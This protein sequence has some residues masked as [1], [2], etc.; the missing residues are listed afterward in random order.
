[1]KQARVSVIKDNIKKGDQV[2]IAKHDCNIGQ[3]VD[4]EMI[5][6][7]H[8][9]DK[10]GVLDIP[11]Y[12]IDNKTRKYG[13]KTHHTIGSQ[14]IRKIL[15]TPNWYDTTF[16]KKTCNQNQIIWNE[17]FQ[18]VV[19]VSIID[20]DLPEIQEKH[21]TAYNDLRNQIIKDLGEDCVIENLKKNY[22]STCGWAVFDRYSHS[23]SFKYRNTDKAM[24][25]IKNLSKSRNTRKALFEE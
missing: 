4:Q 17:D 25:Q 12:N 16:Y 3:W 21:N 2:P 13:S 18:E 5:K 14:T 10:N 7:G 11:E 22:T 15:A 1:M 23:G 6:K 24:K 19:D 8:P 9:V 20:Q